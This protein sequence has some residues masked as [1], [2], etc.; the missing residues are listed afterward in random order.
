MLVMVIRL[1]RLH[2]SP[3]LSVFFSHFTQFFSFP[4]VRFLQL[5][6]VVIICDCNFI[7]RTIYCNFFILLLLSSP[8][9]VTVYAR[10]LSRLFYFFKYIFFSLIM[11]CYRKLGDTY[12]VYF[13]VEKATNFLFDIILFYLPN[14][15]LLIF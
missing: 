2:K 14:I 8:L 5:Y 9:N 3:S 6:N 13:V 4:Y 12:R 15:L 11:K 10:F 7:F 1:R